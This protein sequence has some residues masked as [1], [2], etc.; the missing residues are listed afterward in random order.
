MQRISVL[1]ICGVL[2]M[3]ASG[4]AQN[5]EWRFRW[6]KG[7]VLPYN[8]E[9]VTKVKE[10]VGGKQVESTSKLRLVKRW[11]VTEVD[12]NGVGTLQLSLVSMRHEQT[13]PNGEVL[14]FDSE[15]P[16]KSTPELREQM[17]KYLGTALAQIRVDSQGRVLEASKDAGNKYDSEPPFVVLLPGKAPGP[18][19]GWK[20][21][22]Q[23]KLDPPHGAGEKY[24]ASQTYQCSKVENNQATIRFIT[25]FAALPDN[26]NER[27]PL[28][29]RQPDGVAIFD[30]ESGRLLRALLQTDRTVPNHRGE[31][32]SYHFTSTYDERFV[33]Q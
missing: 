21:T 6:Q 4:L 9:H 33:G 20:R 16:D 24:D 15:N 11:Q 12:A 18:G 2:V 13:R 25:E 7:Q 29:Q 3:A 19:Q 27:M 32:S 14:L 17:K 30:L 1:V 28:L 22:Y 5:S 26:I 8:V 10:T 31:G 23:V